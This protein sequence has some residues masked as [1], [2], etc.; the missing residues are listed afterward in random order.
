[1]LHSLVI[2]IWRDF[3]VVPMGLWILTS[4]T[5]DRDVCLLGDD[6]IGKDMRKAYYVVIGTNGIIITIVHGGKRIRRC[7]E[8]ARLTD[9][10]NG[11]FKVWSAICRW[12]TLSVSETY[13]TLVIE[14]CCISNE[15]C[16]KQE[17]LFSRNL[18]MT[19]SADRR[20][21]R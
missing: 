21:C 17:T 4:I 7:R 6:Q 15:L 3:D 12:D 19:R 18:R 14:T 11:G 5:L 13:I 16:M 2:G 10:G 8:E 9:N 1:M 20:R